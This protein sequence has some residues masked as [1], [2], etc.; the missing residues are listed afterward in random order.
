[1][2]Y[3]Q[4]KDLK[5]E[6]F[7]R[8]CGVHQ[9]TFTRMVSVFQEQVEQKKKKPGKPSK[10]SVEDQVLMSLEYWRE[11]RTY[12][13]IGQSWG[14]H[15][16]TVCRIVTKVENALMQAGIFQMPGKKQLLD[17]EA[18]AKLV[19]IDATETPIERPKKGQKRFYSGK[20]KRHTLKTQLVVDPKTQAV[21]C[22][23]FAAGKEHD[24]HLFKRSKVKLK[25]ETKCLADRGYQGLQKLHSN[26]RLHKK[27]RKGVQLSRADLQMNRD[28]ERVRCICEHIIGRLKVFRIL[29]E[30]YR[31]RRKRFGLRFNL[32]AGLYNYEL[33]LSQPS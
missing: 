17:P 32:I 33:G 14:V 1:M 26:S 18:A 6:E 3:L 19:V 11:Y 25:Q 22:T 27:K 30:R 12:F 9:E 29:A 24:F 23:T 2:T 20:K 8:L 7:K 4:H 5:P 13:H 31:N 16:A 28:I 21:I 15:E 10:L